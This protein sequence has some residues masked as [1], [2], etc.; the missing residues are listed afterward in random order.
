MSLSL[1]AYLDHSDNET[2]IG[3][4]HALAILL[5]LSYCL[6]Y[7][8]QFEIVHNDLKLDNIMIVKEETPTDIRLIDFGESYVGFDIISTSPAIKKG[9]MHFK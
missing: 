2:G 3:C 8:Y 5:R 1:K 7:L 9:N 6:H 4:Y